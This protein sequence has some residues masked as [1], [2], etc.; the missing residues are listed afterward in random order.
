[1]NYIRLGKNIYTKKHLDEFATFQDSQGTRRA[2]LTGTAELVYIGRNDK[3]EWGLA[4]AADG[5]GRIEVGHDRLPEG[6]NHSEITR[7]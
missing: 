6:G 2:Y 1:M 5:L 3:G 4:T 7:M